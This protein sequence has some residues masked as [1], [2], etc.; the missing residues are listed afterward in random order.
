MAL[1]TR[2]FASAPFAPRSSIVGVTGYVK[3]GFE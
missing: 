2:N 3:T 1:P